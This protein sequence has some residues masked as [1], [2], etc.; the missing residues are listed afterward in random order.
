MAARRKNK[1]DLNSV[2]SALVTE[3]QQMVEAQVAQQLAGDGRGKAAKG[4]KKAKAAGAKAATK[5]SGKTGGKRGPKAGF[6][7]E[8]KPCPVCGTPNKARRFS[9]LC[10]SHRDSSSLAKF[11]GAG[12]GKVAAKAV[13]AGRGRKLAAR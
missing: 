2:V 8:L 13:K 5:A 3:L 1:S 6:K 11:K 4:E 9:Y 7:A 10:E 12:R